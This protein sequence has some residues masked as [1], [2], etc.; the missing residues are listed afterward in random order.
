[1]PGAR[2]WPQLERPDEVNELL[3]E[4]AFQAEVSPV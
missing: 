2:Q 3:T 4:F 1:V